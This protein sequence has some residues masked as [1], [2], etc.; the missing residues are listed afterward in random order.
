M[1]APVAAEIYP[2]TFRQVR[3]NFLD[4]VGVSKCVDCS[5]NNLDGIP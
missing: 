4:E 5:Y 1:D 2:Q 3:S